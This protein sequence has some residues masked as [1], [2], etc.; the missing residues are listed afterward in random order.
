MSRNYGDGPK[1]SGSVLANKRGQER[2]KG[3]P[4]PSKGKDCY[5]CGNIR[6]ILQNNVT[7]E[8]LQHVHYGRKEDT[9]PKPV[10]MLRKQEKMEM[11]YVLMASCFISPLLEESNDSEKE[12][13]LIVDTGCAY[14]I[15]NQR[16]VFD[17]LRPCDEKSV[18]DPK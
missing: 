5:V 7:K 18:T 3:S 13:Y 15:V 1:F 16:N 2:Y 10:E 14:H 9:W 8:A 11:Q 6:D 12:S 4:S 17:N